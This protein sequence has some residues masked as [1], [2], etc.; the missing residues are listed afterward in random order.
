MPINFIFIY[1][2]IR[3][4]L[5]F[6]WLSDHSATLYGKGTIWEYYPMLLYS[7]VP[8]LSQAIYGK[9]VVKLNDLEVREEE[10]RGEGRGGSV[11][12]THL[13]PNVCV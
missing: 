6:V 3:I 12:F 11:S 13:T 2:L 7:V 5:Y 9:V 8:P 4:A 10:K 1:A